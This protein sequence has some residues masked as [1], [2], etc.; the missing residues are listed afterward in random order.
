MLSNI[1]A[2]ALSLQFKSI[3]RLSMPNPQSAAI[4]CSTVETLTPY[5]FVNFVQ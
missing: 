5:S 4:K 1:R 2:R 3:R